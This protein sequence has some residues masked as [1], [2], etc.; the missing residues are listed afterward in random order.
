MTSA[1]SALLP[2]DSMA[3]VSYGSRSSGQVVPYSGSSPVPDQQPIFSRFIQR[4]V[5]TERYPQDSNGLRAT[6]LALQVSAL[7]FATSAQAGMVNVNFKAANGNDALGGTFAVANLATFCL[8]NSYN[9]CVLLNDLLRT[10]TPE[11][12][13]LF[14]S[15]IPRY[16]RTT[17]KVIA[18]IVG[19]GSQ[20]PLAYAA[21]DANNKSL[22]YFI[23]R[24]L[25][26]GVP[27]RSLYLSGE[28]I[29]A[30]RH[31]TEVEKKLVKA[32][33]NFCQLLTNA[34]EMLPLLN[35]RSRG[36]IQA[37]MDRH[38]GPAENYLNAL[39]ELAPQNPTPGLAYRAA[40]KTTSAVGYLSTIAVMAIYWALTYAAIGLVSDDE[41]F[42]IFGATAVMLCNYYL[43][44]DAISQT[45]TQALDRTKQLVQRSFKPTIAESL[46][47]KTSVALTATGL[48]LAAFTYGP[49][50]LFSNQYFGA[51]PA[52]A[53]LVEVFSSIGSAF[54]AQWTFST[55]NNAM[56]TAGLARWGSQDAKNV[57]SVD[58]QIDRLHSTAQN[59][60]IKCWA[61]FLLSLPE[62]LKQRILGGVDLSDQEMSDYLNQVGNPIIQEIDSDED[63]GDVPV[64]QPA[65]I[66]EVADD[67]VPAEESVV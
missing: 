12:E 4:M 23:M 53:K 41:G 64:S 7:F 65:S 24:F 47:P 63:I 37:V 6:R 46:L 13:V 9:S 16:V 59:I 32:N 49:N 62:P 31:M 10:L 27:I 60:S 35:E 28:A 29:Y 40:R 21:Y 2:A 14:L 56:L 55:F 15:T 34:K 25:D 30:Q 57:I 58:R 22:F 43:W 19:A 61:E 20:L 44:K 51:S 11:E 66:E 33:E 1:S 18:A 48:T 67:A 3:V 36:Q 38:N 54:L 8:F 50:E 52:G 17:L 26:S 39:V 42:K 5:M 45:A